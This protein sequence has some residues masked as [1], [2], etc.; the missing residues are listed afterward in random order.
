MGERSRTSFIVIIALILAAAVIYSFSISSLQ[1]TPSVGLAGVDASQGPGDVQP[2]PFGDMILVDV[3]PETV[4]SVIETLDRYG[5]YRRTITVE[6]FSGGEAAGG[7]T[8][9]VSV[10]GGW[11]RA[12]VSERSGMTEH[13]ILGEDT[14]WLWYN[15]ERDYVEAAVDQAGAADLI[16]RIPTY[17]DV[18]RL[19]RSRITAAAYERRGEAPCVYVEVREPE[20]EY[21]ERFWI[22]VESGLLVS[23]ETV[24]GEEVVYRMSA[25]EVE[26]PLSD[27][28][29]SFTLPDGTVLHHVEG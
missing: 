15:D 25:Y 8:A 20:L 6:Y 28:T 23:S 9:A 1:R 16:Q 24:K 14:R 3:T 7:L 2:D 5:S 22:S 21:L 12:D 17:E 29:A 27:G 19:D 26:S 11:T 13:S 18:L 4:Q 10:D